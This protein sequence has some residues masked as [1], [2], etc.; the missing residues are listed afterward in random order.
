MDSLWFQNVPI[1]LCTVISSYL[2]CL[3]FINIM[4]LVN[5]NFIQAFII[6]FKEYY[7]KSL[8][9]DNIKII[10][11]DLL[12]IFREYN[13]H[14][15]HI[16]RILCQNII[17]KDLHRQP[18]DMIEFLD[19]KLEY[20]P[21]KCKE[22]NDQT[23]PY[24]MENEYID[25]NISVIAILDN[26]S[27]FKKLESKVDIGDYYEFIS[28]NS[29]KIIEFILTDDIKRESWFKYSDVDDSNRSRIAEDMNQS[30]GNNNIDITITELMCKYIQFTNY[31]YKLIL[32]NIQ[33]LNR[34]SFYYQKL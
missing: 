1:E 27:L 2:E 15:L 23:I 8:N 33:I 7:N 6:N 25:I 28:N 34:I 30:Y 12:R 4:Q 16:K 3:D 10:Y 32:P 26:L 14:L 20:D 11:I 9:H 13:Y 29:Y 19:F 18:S 24:L 31:E 22:Y 21:Y 5:I 17:D